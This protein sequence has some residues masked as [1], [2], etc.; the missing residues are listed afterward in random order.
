MS[1]HFKENTVHSFSNT[2]R[3]LWGGGVCTSVKL[4]T[5]HY[6]VLYRSQAGY[7]RE[8]YVNNA[9]TETLESK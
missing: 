5:R 9:S 4:F 6:L 1:T 7:L 8:G 3:L 2:Y